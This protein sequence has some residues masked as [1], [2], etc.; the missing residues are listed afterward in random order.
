MLILNIN[1]INRLSRRATLLLEGRGK[2]HF[3]NNASGT[4]TTEARS[5]GTGGGAVLWKWSLGELSLFSMLFAYYIHQVNLI[6][7]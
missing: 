5:S 1:L 2:H 6:N 4:L 7:S 3:G